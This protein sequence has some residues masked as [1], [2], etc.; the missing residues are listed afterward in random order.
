M[1]FDSSAAAS[2]IAV[3]EVW[4]R[5]DRGDFLVVSRSFP[6]G[7]GIKYRSHPKFSTICRLT[8]VEGGDD[9]TCEM[10]ISML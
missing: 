5:G 8:S 10:N 2:V 9:K 6:H 4:P 1:A 3:D 7:G